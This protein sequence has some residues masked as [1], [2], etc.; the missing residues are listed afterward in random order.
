MEFWQNVCF[1]ETTQLVEIARITEACGY[2]G[3]MVSDH[4]VHP[5]D[6]TSHYPY[7][8]DGRISWEAWRPWPDPWVLI[9]S[10]AA[11]TRRLRFMTTTYIAPARNPFVVAKAV[12]TAAVLSDNRVVLGLGA[13]WFRE[14]FELMGQEFDN[15]G[16][17]LDEMIE[18]LRLLWRGGFVEYEGEHYR[19]GRVQMNPAPTRQVPIYG[20]GHSAPAFRRAARLD[21][22]IGNAYT[23]EDALH[24][25][26]QLQEARA[27]AGTLDR[28]D[29]GTVVAVQADPFDLD[30][31]RRLE[32]AGVTTILCVPWLIAGGA[33]RTG[34]PPEVL[35]GE[36]GLHTIDEA[37]A[38]EGPIDEKRRAIEEF[39]ERVI[40]KMR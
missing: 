28:S 38:Y 29:Y 32:D 12:G 24:F 13:G 10:M 30:V 3:I 20:A 18:V 35:D 5:E 21:G 19:F 16:A 33:D 22:W 7:T 25:L 26:A 27:A 1:I 6:A 34:P 39:A 8:P 2:D 23:P 31:Y 15:R 37:A 14:E 9:G 36:R 4:V 40:D 11:V 17:R